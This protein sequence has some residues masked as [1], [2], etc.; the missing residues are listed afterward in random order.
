MIRDSEV[1]ERGSPLDK[2]LGRNV[3]SYTI[4]CSEC[5]GHDSLKVT[6]V[7]GALGI[8]MIKKTF[9]NRGWYVAK[10]RKDDICPSCQAKLKEQRIIKK[11]M[12]EMAVTRA[13]ESFRRP[14][15]VERPNAKAA[16]EAAFKS[17]SGD[18]GVAVNPPIGGKAV[19]GL[20]PSKDMKRSIHQAILANYRGPKTGYVEGVTDA[21]LAVELGSVPISWVTDIRDE[22]FGPAVSASHPDVKELLT[23]IDSLKAE[24]ALFYER[25]ALLAENAERLTL[26]MRAL[27]KRTDQL[28]GKE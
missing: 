13:S 22:F 5:D 20:G 24:Q 15:L 2:S 14:D 27:E 6:K 3:P 7:G 1:F 11:D 19:I 10:K 16:A 17:V 28:R 26:R 21:S 9:A 4:R 12:R 25:Q 23:E 8:E 18:S